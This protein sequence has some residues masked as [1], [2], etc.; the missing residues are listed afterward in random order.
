[1]RYEL[2]VWIDN[3][4]T[5]AALALQE[6]RQMTRT[7]SMGLA[8]FG[9][10][11]AAAP[12]AGGSP[13]NDPVSVD[14]QLSRSERGLKLSY[15]ITN[16]SKERIY[17]L[18]QMVAP[19]G[20]TYVLT[21]QAVVVQGGE[22]GTVDFVR[23]FVDP[24]HPVQVQYAPAARSLD[25]GKTLEG[26]AEVPLPLQAQHPYGRLVPLPPG[27]KVATLRVGYV[28]AQAQWTRYPM[29]DGTA[30]TAPQL[31][32][33]VSLQRFARSEQKPLP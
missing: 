6:E 14:L 1:M 17:V 5:Q 9:L 22:K 30:L 11:L 28:S 21:P 24:G 31:P 29:A 27:L 32:S 19:R 15:S 12:A 13:M 33:V 7:A 20:S 3:R 25:P 8:L 10:V 26:T 4:G 23:G 16:R 2:R 18:D